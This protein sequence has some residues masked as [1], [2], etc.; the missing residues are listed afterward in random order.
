MKNKRNV[1]YCYIG[2]FEVMRDLDV[3]KFEYGFGYFFFSSLIVAYNIS[4]IVDVI[5]DI[6]Q[7]TNG[8]IKECQR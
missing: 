2:N 3:V 8:V 5:V 1:L 7:Q 6:D 4:F